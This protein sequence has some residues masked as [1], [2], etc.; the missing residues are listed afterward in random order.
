M[1]G[2]S[3]NI[4]PDSPSVFGQLYAGD[5]SIIPWFKALTDGVRKHG[6]AVM[7]Q[8]TH[9]GRRTVWDDGHW[10]PVMGPSSVRERAHRSSPKAMEVE[11][12]DR[13][14]AHFVDAALRCQQGGFD[15]IELLSH[16]HLLGQFLSPLVNQRKDTYGGSLENRMRL[17]LQVIKAVR[18]A[19]GSDFILGV[20]ATGDELVKG[21]LSA[22]ECVEIAMALSETGALDFLNILAG[23]P[24]D[25]LGLAG[26][27]P[28]MGMPAAP[29][30][31]IAGRIRR[32]V[33]IPIFHA[34][35]IADIA[36][37]RHA[38]SEGH[39]DLVGMTRAHLADPYLVAKLAR[40]D[41][42]RI[43]PCV[44]LGYCV[45][46]VNQGKDALC[47]HN[48]A[49]GREATM[50]HIMR[51]AEVRKTVVIVG[52]G[53]GGLEAARVSAERNHHTIL[54]EASDRL[55]GQL[56]IASRGQTRRQ[57]AAVTDWLVHEVD[58]LGVD[59][60]LNRFAEAQDVIAEKPDVVVVATGGW[61]DEVG[62][63]GGD[64]AVSSWEVLGGDA[65][66]SGEILLI[67]EIGDQSAAVCADFL[68]RQGCA[69]LMV[70]PDRAIALDLGPTNSSVVLRDLAVQNVTF[71]CFHELLKIE[72]EGNRN[73]ATLR[74]VLTDA[75]EV[76]S[77]DH[78]VVEQGAAPMDA[79][80]HA[81]KGSSRNA[82]QLNQAAMIAGASPFVDV[83]GEGSF[84]LARI[85]DAVANR[86]IHAALYD[87]LRVCKDI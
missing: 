7:C 27:V 56:N 43:R 21:G 87:A 20:R 53:P 58:L 51:A 83:G 2:G 1:I 23:A 33:A 46:R 61:A 5:D 70:T 65:R 55:G 24:Y 48:A 80:Y 45:D 76:R 78:V 74:H 34:G 40:G 9:M 41:G 3:T 38:L 86:N 52:G 81:L 66:V 63:P 32:A 22:D 15:G 54:F 47:G 25:D 42:H 72:K 50:P 60:R 62:V 4:S 68:A 73:K 85:G 71:Q 12:I 17:S 36:T 13:V 35:G 6:A 26:W 69:V 39:V 79:I 37:A 10:L 14:I 30:L 18:E 49:T 57:I 59:V 29:H 16:S 64:L 8:I 11:D 77:V 31:S 67:D 28:P 19:V 82:G 75:T 84:Y 44:G